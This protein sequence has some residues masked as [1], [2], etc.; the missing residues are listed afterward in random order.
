MCISSQGDFARVFNRVHGILEALPE[1]KTSGTAPRRSTNSTKLKW[2]NIPELGNGTPWFARC[3]RA[4]RG[5]SICSGPARPCLFPG[6][7]YLQHARTVSGDFREGDAGWLGVPK[8]GPPRVI[9]TPPCSSC[10]SKRAERAVTR[11]EETGRGKRAPP[12]GK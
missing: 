8:S 12:R 2:I 6:E 11:R 9:T 5:V 7:L 10:F 1:I 4:P 3:T